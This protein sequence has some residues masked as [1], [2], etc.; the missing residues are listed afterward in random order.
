MKIR[1]ILYL[2]M[3][4]LSVA[5]V[6]CSDIGIASTLTLIIAGMFTVTELLSRLADRYE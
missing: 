2:I 6:G 3:M 4:I 5:A 1:Y